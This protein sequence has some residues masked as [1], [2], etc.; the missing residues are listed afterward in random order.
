M[1]TCPGDFNDIL[2]AEQAIREEAA[3][4][5]AEQSAFL[6]QQ[7]LWSAQQRHR[8]ELQRTEFTATLQQDAARVALL[9]HNSRVPEDAILG[10]LKP[11]TLGWV[12]HIAAVSEHNYGEG[13]QFRS[14]TEVHATI[15]ST[16]GKLQVASPVLAKPRDGQLSNRSALYNTLRRSSGLQDISGVE[17]AQ[18][19]LYK[20]QLASFVL[21][22]GLRQ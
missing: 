3:C 19:N 12:I 17:L 9:A 15:L 7:D 22:Q 16:Q 20:R 6:R 8:S 11:R 13:Y 10:R 18:L 1:D 2:S 14:W 5:A 4:L 21:D